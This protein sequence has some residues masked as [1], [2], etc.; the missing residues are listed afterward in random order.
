MVPVTDTPLRTEHADGVTTVTLHRPEAMNAFDHALKEALLAALTQAAED[1]AVRCVVLTGEGRAFG[2]GQDLKEHVEELR[3]GRALGDTVLQ[4]YNPITTLLATMEKPVVASLNG[5]AAG[6]A[7]SFALAADLRYAADTAGINTAF[8]AIGLSCDSGASWY[9]PRLLGTAR[10]KELL[11]LPRT[12]SAAECL[13][14]G[15]V[16]EVVPADAL[17]TRV[18]EVAAR[19][20]AGPTL[21][22]GSI[23]RAVAYSAAHPLADSLAHEARLMNLTGRSEDHERA[24]TAFLAKEKPVFEG[25]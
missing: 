10:A 21:A 23:R 4:H 17:A 8:A 19:L 6:A 3:S 18:H 24:V 12:L 25:R 11:L 20:A 7:A 2:V 15:L 1:P 16:T 13:E 9:L 14:L 22:Y 5:V